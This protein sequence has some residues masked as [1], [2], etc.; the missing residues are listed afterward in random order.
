MA[1]ATHSTDSILDATRRI[2][3][4]RGTRAATLEEIVRES[5]APTG[6]IYYRFG[7]ID[8]LLAQLWLR[9]A[10]RS[11]AIIQ[12]VQSDDAVESVVAGAISV[13]ELCL[14]EPE[15]AVLLSSFSPNDFLN[16]ELDDEL[17]EE[18]RTVNAPIELS[19]AEVAAAIFGRATPESI[20]EVLFALV[21]LPYDFAR[22]Q[23]STGKPKVDRPAQLESCVRTLLS[24]APNPKQKRK[25]TRT[26]KK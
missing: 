24:S 3:V 19:L 21:R 2:V 22:H 5:G 10:R 1:R 11:H 9:A 6:S 15:D 25:G 18:L 26:A 16:G 12:E 13:Y 23:V 17:R 20:N 14:R 4:K 7:S 8:Q